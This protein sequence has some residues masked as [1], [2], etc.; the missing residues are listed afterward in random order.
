MELIKGIRYNVAT[1]VYEEYEEMAEMP[2][3]R[4]QEIQ[5]RLQEI[6]VLLNQGDWKTIKFIE[7]G[8]DSPEFTAHKQSRQL[9]RDEYNTLEEE[10]INL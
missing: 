2:N 10:L 1:K 4:I 8:V 9:L 7:I 6:R 3:P 5:M